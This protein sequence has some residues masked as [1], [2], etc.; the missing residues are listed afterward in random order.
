[1]AKIGFVGTGNMGGALAVS[2]CK[3]VDPENVILSNRT[4]K[5]NKLNHKVH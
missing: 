5:T 1:M 3:A 4:K 2:V